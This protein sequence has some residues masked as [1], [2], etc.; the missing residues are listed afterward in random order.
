[1]NFLFHTPLTECRTPL[2]GFCTSVCRYKFIAT[3]FRL[4]KEVDPKGVAWR[5]GDIFLA[6]PVNG[7]QD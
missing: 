7:L 5:R 4:I 6:D 3:R 1:M 2:A